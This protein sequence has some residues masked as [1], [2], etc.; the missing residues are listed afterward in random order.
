MQGARYE[1]G[2]DNS[3]MYDGEFFKKGLKTH[4]AGGGVLDPP[5]VQGLGGGGDMDCYLDTMAR[6]ASGCDAMSSPS[7]KWP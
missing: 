5:F 2:L 6:V 1:S 3:P 7:S 4:G